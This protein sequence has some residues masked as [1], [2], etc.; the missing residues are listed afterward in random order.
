MPIHFY[1]KS[2][3][4]SEFSNFAPFPIAIDGERWPSVEH[5]YQA[6][7]TEDLDVREKIRNAKHPAEAKKRGAA[8]NAPMRADWEAVK[9]EIMHRAVQAKFTSHESLA[10][11]LLSTGNEE[12]VEAVSGDGYWGAGRDGGGQNKLGKILMRVR[13]DLRAARGD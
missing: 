12:L 5:Y 10:L 1:S 3:A 13:E 4:F 8:S 11:L 7:K 6:Q 2:A 9:D